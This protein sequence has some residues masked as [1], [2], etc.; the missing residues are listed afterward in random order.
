ESMEVSIHDFTDWR[1]QQRQS[2]VDL[3]AW[4]SGTI[5]VA[6][7]GVPERYDGAFITP[8]SFPL[9]GVSPV[10]GRLFREAEASS[11]A[12]MVALIGHQRGQERYG[13]GARS[14]GRVGRING[15]PAT[16]VGVRPEGFLF[17]FEQQV[18]VPLR[19]DPLVLARGEGM[20]L[21]VF[22]RLRPGL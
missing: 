14:V 17:P 12:P 10:L 11:S 7:R 21:E 16:M 22:G 4:Y 6:D 8:S 19:L 3:G 15:E 2:F 20:S 18:W 13:A 5:N 9:L 1:A